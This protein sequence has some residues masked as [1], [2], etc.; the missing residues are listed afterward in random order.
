MR[1]LVVTSRFPEPGKR[2]DQSRAFAFLSF[3]AQR[4]ELSIVSGGSASSPEAGHELVSRC[5]LT[6]PPVRRGDRARSAIAAALRRHPSQVGWMMPTSVWREAEVRSR[7]CDVVLINTVRSLRSQLQVP[8][9]VDFV[10][11]LSWNMRVRSRGQ[12]PWP[13]RRYARLEARLLVDWERTVEGWA[14]ASIVTSAGVAQALP[15]P[16][17]HAVIPVPW[18]EALVDRDQGAR[19]IDLIMTG[20]MR[21]PPNRQ[22]ALL[23]AREI[24]PRV[25]NQRP[26]TSCWIVGRHAARLDVQE[27]EVREN[28]PDVGAYLR[29]AKVAVAPV[30]GRG[31]PYKVLEA[32]AHGAAVVAQPWALDAYG[33]RG[34]SAGDAQSFASASVSLLNSPKLRDERVRQAARA[35]RQHTIEK[36]GAR[37]EQALFDAYERKL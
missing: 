2:G 22:G 11:A 21:Y 34:E 33:L 20:D 30:I 19:D 31:S 18:V 26:G 6:V 24:L 7:S 35:V 27:I 15:N 4:H 37:Y 1:V 9:V 10:D 16:D 14:A 23:L 3:L 28:V 36:L 17:R 13:V 32:A 5:E 12:E 8:M 25:R 29:R